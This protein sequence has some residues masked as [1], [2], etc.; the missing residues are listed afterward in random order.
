MSKKKDTKPSANLGILATVLKNGTELL[1]ETIVA[2]TNDQ[3]GVALVLKNPCVIHTVPTDQGLA[4][5]LLPYLSYAKN[6]EVPI[7]LD[8]ILT[9]VEVDDDLVNEYRAG[10]GSGIQVPSNKIITG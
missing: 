2:K 10:F 6:N 3:G 8:N 4:H 1:A 9:Q 7:E 5:A